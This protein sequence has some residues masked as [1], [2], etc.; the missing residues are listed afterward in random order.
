MTRRDCDA[1]GEGD[2][3]FTTFGTRG[4]GVCV[5]RGVAAG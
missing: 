2:R 5:K 1:K 4:R 3:T